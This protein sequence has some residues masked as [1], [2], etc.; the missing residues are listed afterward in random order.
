MFADKVLY[1][2][3][4]SLIGGDTC[5]QKRRVRQRITFIDQLLRT[6]YLTALKFH[7][8]A[9]HDEPTNHYPIPNHVYTLLPFPD[10][11]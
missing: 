9:F 8:F 7:L 11:P 3:D 4:D 6:S 5:S 2:N 1:H 10:L